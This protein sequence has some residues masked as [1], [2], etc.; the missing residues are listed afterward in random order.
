[1]DAITT[2]TWQKE[3]KDIQKSTNLFP[4]LDLDKI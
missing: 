1:M 4:V 3:L 2:W